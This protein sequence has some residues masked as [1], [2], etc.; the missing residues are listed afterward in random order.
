[1]DSQIIQNYQD[2]LEEIKKL[3]AQRTN[4]EK[5]N[6]AE[7]KCVRTV[8]VDATGEKKESLADFFEF[9]DKNS[10]ARISFSGEILS[11]MHQN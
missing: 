11:H 4:S 3:D 10:D 7:Q 5:E 8:L 6:K 9:C 1:M 2:A